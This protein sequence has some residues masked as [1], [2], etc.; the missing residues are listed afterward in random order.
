[1]IEKVNTYKAHCP[2]HGRY[3]TSLLRLYKSTKHRTACRYELSQ[4]WH[5]FIGQEEV[6]RLYPKACGRPWESFKY[7]VG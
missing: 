7:A 4:I 2:V 3:L 6:F 1:M 5:D